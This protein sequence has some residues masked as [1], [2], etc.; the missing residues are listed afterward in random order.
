V[1]NGGEKE[2]KR[3]ERV[4]AFGA[5]MWKGRKAPVFH[6]RALRKWKKKKGKRK[7]KKNSGGDALLRLAA[8]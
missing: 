8:W 7:R 1:G 6:L 2:E 3:G 5:I 4:F